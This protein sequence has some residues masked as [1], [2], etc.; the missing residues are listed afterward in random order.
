[1]DWNSVAHVNIAGLVRL[2]LTSR[3]VRV[4]L[5]ARVLE[6]GERPG[7]AWGPAEA[8]M[9]GRLQAARAAPVSG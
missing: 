9:I 1:M 4:W 2:G 7:R 3:K 5:I 6:V 8:P